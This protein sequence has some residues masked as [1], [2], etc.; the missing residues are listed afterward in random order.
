MTLE[1]VS[2]PAGCGDE[3]VDRHV[4]VGQA[5]V[6]EERHVRG[7][8]TTPDRGGPHERVEDGRL[9][10][11]DGSEIGADGESRFWGDGRDGGP[12]HCGA[13]AHE[14]LRDGLRRRHLDGVALVGQRVVSSSSTSPVGSWRPTS[15]P[16]GVNVPFSHTPG[17]S[18]RVAWEP[19]SVA[20]LA[21]LPLKV[22]RARRCAP[23]AEARVR[24]VDV[25]DHIECGGVGHGLH[26]PVPDGRETQVHG[27]GATP[28]QQD[29]RDRHQNEGCASLVSNSTTRFAQI[30]VSCPMSSGST[31][32][33]C[34]STRWSRA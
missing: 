21:S 23:V 12:G 19:L 14:D 9:L 31:S 30:H 27:E 15:E 17:V 11:V 22:C 20:A 25:T 1:V 5:L 6:A 18:V 32:A 7:I 8:P 10:C 28:Q 34:C 26:L 33:G 29:H 24:D 2:R 4:G 16:S 3:L 13:P